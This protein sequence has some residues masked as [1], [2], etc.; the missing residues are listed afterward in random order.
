MTH[1]E[2]RAAIARIDDVLN[3]VESQTQEYEQVVSDWLNAENAEQGVEAN[4]LLADL[5]RRRQALSA[6]GS[7]IQA[8]VD[9]QVE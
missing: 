8:I 2:D 3:E 4:G 6:A 1:P 5:D 7:L 9:G